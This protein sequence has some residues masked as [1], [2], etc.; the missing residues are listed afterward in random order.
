MIAVE[1]SYQPSDRD[2]SPRVRAAFS[3]VRRRMLP[4]IAQQRYAS[5]KAAFDRK[6]FATAA[7]G[8]RQV[9]DVL[10]DPDVAPAANQSPL[11][12]MRTLAAGFHDLSAT[13]AAPPPPPPPPP[14]SPAPDPP[15]AP[16][17]PPRIYGPGDTDVVPPVIVRQS[18]P[19]IPVQAQRMG[20]PSLGV[21][22]VVIDQSGAVEAVVMKASFSPAYDRQIVAAAQEWL[23]KPATLSGVPV[24]YRKLVQIA[25][26]R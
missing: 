15:P 20:M 13:A 18:L 1:P 25:I 24:K 10:A 3:D 21:I 11:S 8:F 6:E 9:L 4:T 23:Y 2:V 5:A 22:E 17:L 7:S 12:D 14:P 19:N 16:A 26:K